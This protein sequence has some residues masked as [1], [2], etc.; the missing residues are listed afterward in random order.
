MPSGGT[1]R[2]CPRSAEKLAPIAEQIIERYNVKI[3]PLDKSRFLEEVKSFLSIYNRSLTNTWGFVP[4]SDAE[5]EHV[6]KALNF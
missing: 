2:C 1:S 4:M 5:V 3:R 6:A